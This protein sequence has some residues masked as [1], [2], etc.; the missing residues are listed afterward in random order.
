MLCLLRACISY[1]SL[2]ALGGCQNISVLPFRESVM[3]HLEGGTQLSVLEV[4]D[5]LLLVLV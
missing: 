2:Y 4:S 5:R 1:F 3:A